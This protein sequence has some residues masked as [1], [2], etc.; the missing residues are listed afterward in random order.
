MTITDLLIIYL[1]FG[2]PVAVYK[3]LQNRAFGIRPRIALSVFTFFFWVPTIVKLSYLYF[4]NA[5]FSDA[6]VSHRSSDALDRRI[7]DLRER[8]T[9][10]MIR[11]ARGSN[12]HDTRETVDRYTGLADAVRQ[13]TSDKEGRNELFEAAGRENYGLGELVMVRRNLHRLRRHHIHARR[14]FLNLLDQVSR[15][16]GSID[17][18]YTGIDL[19]SELGDLEAVERLNALKVKRGEVW[20]AVQHE[21]ARAIT[22]APPIVMTGSLHND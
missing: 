3:Y 21:E 19:A 5:Y 15:R 18:L 9:A 16:F 1:A 4:S 7:R 14:D 6:F 20:T 22:P 8:I 10:E 12:L 2:A 17:L 13:G 11:L